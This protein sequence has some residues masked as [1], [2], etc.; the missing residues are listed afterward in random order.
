MHG[1]AN[2]RGRVFRMPPMGKLSA[3]LKEFLRRA[4]V[5]RADLF[6]NDAT[7]KAL[8]LHDLRASGIT[9]MGMRGDGAMRIMRRAGHKYF[10][11]TQGYLPEAENLAAG[12]GDVF[13]PLPLELLEKPTKRRRQAWRVERSHVR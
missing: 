10:T 1:E 5:T 3:K 13:P 9:W 11:T 2:G 8:R 4:G 12:F 6:T 7:R